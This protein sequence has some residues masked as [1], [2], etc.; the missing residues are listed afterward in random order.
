V[1]DDPPAPSPP[2]DRAGPAGRPP[3]ADRQG[4]LGP[5]GRPP[6][7]AGQLPAGPA[8]QVD[9]RPATFRDVFAVREF[10]ALYFACTLSWLGDYLARAAVTVLVYQ[11]TQ[12]VLLS[13]ASFAVSYLPWILG[14]PLLAA[15]AERYPYRR[16]MI[17][18][19]LLR[20]SLIG[21]VAIPGLPIGAILALLFLAMLAN[22]PT[23]AARS[24]LMPLILSRDRLVVGIAVN[25]ST[26]QAAQVVGYLAGAALAAAWNP[27]LALV[28]DAATFAIS[29]LLIAGGIRNRPPAMTAAHRSH[30]LRETA[31]GFRVVFGD[32]V[33]RSVAVLVFALMLFAIVPEGLAA[34]WAAQTNPDPSSRGLAQGMIMAANPV[35]FV[36]G[37]LLI[38]RFV[39]PATRRRLIRPLA[40][41]AP[42][43]L[44]PALT[45]PSAP[46]VA[47][48][49]M[50]SGFAVAG[51]LP[52]LNGM[53]V[54]ALRHGFRARAFGVMQGGLQLS[55]GGAVLITGLLADRFPLPTVV[56]L[57]SVGGTLL[58]LLVVSR[59][60]SAHSFNAAIAAATDELPVVARRPEDDDATRVTPVAPG[61]VPVPPPPA[62]RME[63]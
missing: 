58:M 22:P 20:M 3:D 1:S 41:I 19:D 21:L 26:S 51:L 34:A 25:T 40:V 29:A 37:G 44:V 31:D 15:L 8:G 42:L 12:S 30:L 43:A 53:F 24:A 62:G 45:A 16:V 61:A 4:P 23:Q 10:R 35:G 63:R 48:M 2:D 39:A 52:T 18:S 13:A 38:G 59:W 46:V 49:A 36:L 11:Q 28:L 50:V 32:Q 60:P 5:A 14:G 47:L 55:Q 57:W 17:F 56:G 27:R 54:L 7:A 9:E 33:L 6:A